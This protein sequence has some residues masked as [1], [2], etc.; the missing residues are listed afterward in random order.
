MKNIPRK[1]FLQVDEKGETPDDFNE[2]EGVT[3]CEDRINDNDLEYILKEIT[4]E[5]E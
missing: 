2:L 3:W 5:K 1:I 4:N